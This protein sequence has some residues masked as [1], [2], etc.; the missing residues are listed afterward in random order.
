MKSFI[1]IMGHREDQISGCEDAAEELG[2][3]VNAN[4]KFKNTYACS[5]DLW[6]TKKRPKL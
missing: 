2:H 1:N 5:V 4:D 3:L 6:N